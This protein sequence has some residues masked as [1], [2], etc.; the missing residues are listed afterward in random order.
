MT[1]VC[2]ALAVLGAVS[3]GA[4]SLLAGSTFPS[5]Q[6]DWEI[7]AMAKNGTDAP[8]DA[9]KEAFIRA[10][11]TTFVPIVRSSGA[12]A[13][14]AKLTYEITSKTE[15]N[16]FEMKIQKQPK[17]DSAPLPPV[18]ILKP[19]IYEFLRDGTLKVAWSENVPGLKDANGKIL[20]PEQK[21]D[22]PTDFK[23]GV[24]QFSITLKRKMK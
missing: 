24:G 6:G 22:R 1:R 7:I 15:I 10:T 3:V 8:L 20:V 9:V 2:L 4:A 11:A 14:D 12:E 23:G 18:R 19:G 17:N 21:I 5:L 16:F 13:P